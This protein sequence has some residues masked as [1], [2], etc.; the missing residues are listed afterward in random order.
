M[1]L[2][3]PRDT[4]LFDTSWFLTAP[5][6]KELNLQSKIEIILCLDLLT[7]EFV[8]PQAEVSITLT[9]NQKLCALIISSELVE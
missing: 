9:T 6:A 5:D 4:E 8:L 2:P 3:E 7:A 1:I